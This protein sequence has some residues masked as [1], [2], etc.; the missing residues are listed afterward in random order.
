MDQTEELSFTSSTSEISRPVTEKRRTLRTYS[1]R[2]RSTEDD[3]NAKPLKRQKIPIDE[4][5]VAQS[6]LPRPS[7]KASNIPKSSILSYFKPCRS[8][9][10]TEASDPLSDSEKLVNTPPS[11][12]PVIRRIREPRRLRLRHS[13]ATIPS[14]DTINETEEEADDK[15]VNVEVATRRITRSSKRVTKQLQETTESKLNERR[16]GVKAKPNQQTSK[17]N[18]RSKS[19]ATIQTT[20]NISS[21][22]TFEECKTCRIVYNPLHPPDVKYHSQRHAAYLRGR[23]R[24]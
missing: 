19:T 16:K 12:P 3:A 18:L 21:K 8:S 11:S 7:A 10:A 14:S 9:S 6:E 1:K 20:I 4:T 23:P 22:P 15:W 5:P 13:S 24:T 2:S 17:P